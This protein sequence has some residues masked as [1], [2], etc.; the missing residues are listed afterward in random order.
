MCVRL[1]SGSLHFSVKH[2]W[3]FYP[4]LQSSIDA[5]EKL[6]FVSITRPSNFSNT[7]RTVFKVF[8]STI[9]ATAGPLPESPAPNA[10]ASMAESAGRESSPRTDDTARPLSVS[11]S[12]MWPLLSFQ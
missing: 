12:Q 7:C 1:G 8:L 2:L 9:A 4:D 6:G 3:T 10:P 11:A 5:F